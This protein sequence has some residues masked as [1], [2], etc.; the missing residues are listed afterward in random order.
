MESLTTI[1]RGF[2]TLK[3]SSRMVKLVSFSEAAWIMEKTLN[4]WLNEKKQ[5]TDGLI[6]LMQSAHQAFSEWCGF[7]KTTG[8]AE[9]QFDRLHNLINDLETDEITLQSD[10]EQAASNNQLDTRNTPPSAISIGGITVPTDLFEIFTTESKQHLA[11]LEQELEVLH[12]THPAVV[13]D[14]LTLATHTL[15]STS[16]A[17]KLNFIADLSGKLEAWLTQLKETDTQLGNSDINLIQNCTEQ[18]GELLC[19][20]H[21]QQFPDETDLKLSQLLSQE[22]SKRRQKDEVST[23]TASEPAN[24]DEHKINETPESVHPEVSSEHPLEEISD[25]ETASSDLLQTFFEETHE[26]IPQLNAQLRAWRILPQD[27]DVRL[28]LLRL[29]HTLKGSANMIGAQQLGE[30]VHSTEEEI[31]QAFNDVVVPMRSIETVEYQFDQI[32]EAIEQLQHH[33]TVV[34]EPTVTEVETPDV[35]NTPSDTTKSALPPVTSIPKDPEPS[36][37]TF[38]DTHQPIN[39]LR[40]HAEL[41]DRLV[42]ESGEA[43]IIRNKIETQLNQSKQSLQ[44]LTES[45][46]RLHE[47]LREIEIQAETQ[48]STQ[49]TPQSNHEHFVDPLELDR[50]TRL[51]ELTR[52]MAESIDDVITVQ[53]NLNTIHNTATEAVGQQAIINHRLQQELM[54]IRT[55]PFESISERYYRVIRKT[56]NDL[57]KKVNL[58]IQGKA[59]EIDRSVL[60]KLSASLEHILRNAVVHG[61]EKPDY[62]TQLGKPEIGQIGINIHQ[63]SSEVTITIRDDGSG[64]NLEKIREEAIKKRLI[65]ADEALDNEQIA[66]L[67]FAPGLTT[68]DYATDS[69]GRGMG[70]DIVQN[71]ISG[72]GGHI[73]VRSAKDKGTIFYIQLPIMLAVTRALLVSSGNQILAIPTTIVAHAQELNPDVLHTAYQEQQI[74]HNNKTYPFTY[75]PFYLGNLDTVPETKR[76]NQIL[77]LQNGDLKLAVHVDE[78]IGN[79]EVIVKKIGPQIMHAPGVESATVTGDGKPAL[80]LNPLKLLQREDVQQILKTPVA[81]IISRSTRDNQHIATVLVVDDALTVRKVVSRLLEQKGYNVLTAKQGIEA[82]ETITAIKPEIILT[83]LEMPKMNGFELIKT[84]RNNPDTTHIPIIVITS[85]T[86]EKHHKM[87]TQLGANGFMGKPYNEDELLNAISQCLPKES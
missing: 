65:N 1:R 80:I 11:T 61:I 28:N 68:Q 78:L 46:D 69:A 36:A 14:P 17:I 75:L 37:T 56:A 41:I 43:S 66:A 77:L 38:E 44:D 64:L 72:L 48:I 24:A 15:A 52:L 81:D 25:N 20:V 60:E 54:R 70:M 6:N 86:A 35:P 83:D 9:I 29:L 47:Q 49:T 16:R 45:I 5:I 50:Y 10:A 13:N 18:I 82:M 53:K 51:Q 73:T 21:Q 67:I 79:H 87:A 22:I 84:I 19:K 8:E 31:Q 59:I 2:H 42:N 23:P 4:H 30:L 32:C 57:G 3:G 27:E 62:R 76:R 33:P 85:R 58:Q 26:I 74:I 40:V 63:D 71:D 34:E 12:N 55:V 39:I 7:L